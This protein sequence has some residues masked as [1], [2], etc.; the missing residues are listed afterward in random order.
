MFDEVLKLQSID[1][2]ILYLIADLWRVCIF[3]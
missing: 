1:G 2:I 3:W